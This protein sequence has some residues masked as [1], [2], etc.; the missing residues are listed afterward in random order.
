PAVAVLAVAALLVPAWL[1]T[2][3]VATERTEGGELAAVRR[4][5]DRLA[6]GDVVV[7]LDPRGSNE[8]PQVLRG[9]CGVPAASV[10]VVGAG[11]EAAA[12][13][14]TVEPARRIAQRIAAS[15]SPARSRAGPRWSGSGCSP[16]PPSGC[17]P[18]RTS[19]C[20]PGGRTASRRSA[21]R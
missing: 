17:A 8:W 20:S 16:R 5:C 18:P 21:S 4:V 19:G 10:R 1:G 6:D 3:A 13:L 9:M 14:A 12:A 15:G 11:S 2:A 7:A